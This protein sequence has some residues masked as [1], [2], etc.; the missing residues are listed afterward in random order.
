VIRAYATAAY[1]TD[2]FQGSVG[3]LVHADEQ[4]GMAFGV[5]AENWW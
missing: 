3:G 2:D 4:F 1:W 5:Q